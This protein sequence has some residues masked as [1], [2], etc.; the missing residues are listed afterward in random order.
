MELLEQMLGNGNEITFSI[1][2]IVILLYVIK[3]NDKREVKYQETIDKNQLI[4]G[5]TIILLNDLDEMK[6][7][8]NK[9]S[10]KIG[11]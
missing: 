9:I 5:N 11:A 7:N 1:L 4:I 2:F 10:D 3:T 8:I 6:K